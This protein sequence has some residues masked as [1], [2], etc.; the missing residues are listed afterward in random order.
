MEKRK[1]LYLFFKE[2]INNAA[3]YSAAQNVI[4]RVHKKGVAIEMVIE[5]DGRGFDTNQVFTSNGMNTLKRRATELNAS[6]TITSQLN[7]GTQIYL[8][9]KIT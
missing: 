4:V 5:D 8:S 3:K 6:H 1:N 7:K 2:A 9:F